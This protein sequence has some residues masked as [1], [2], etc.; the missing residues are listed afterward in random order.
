[1]AAFGSTT[2]ER[3]A[4]TTSKVFGQAPGATARETV[5][6]AATED[7]RVKTAVAALKCLCQKAAVAHGGNAFAE[8]CTDK[9]DGT[10]GW[11][12]S[13]NP[14]EVNIRTLAKACPSGTGK[15]VT[16]RDLTKAMNDLQKLIHKDSKNGYLGFFKTTGCT[17]N[18]GRG[19]CIKFTNYATQGQDAFEKIPWIAGIK[20]LATKLAERERAAEKM[21]Q[22]N[23]ILKLSAETATENIAL[24]AALTE[25]AAAPPPTAKKTDIS[26]ADEK[27]KASTQYKKQHSADRRENANG[28]QQAKQMGSANL[29]MEKDRQTQ[30]EHLQ[31]LQRKRRKRR[32]VQNTRLIRENMKVTKVVNGREK[33]AKIPVFS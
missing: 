32:N 19:Q 24:A 8:A 14:N 26:A 29:K 18:S 22:F 6:E 20:G 4:V 31:D 2:E 25:I 7:K 13:S 11:D 9:P 33:L 21:Q 23:T 10:N 5:C 12:T 27:K 30:Q 1:M 15:H 3:S 16:S 28:K 17:G